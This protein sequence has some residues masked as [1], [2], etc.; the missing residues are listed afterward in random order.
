MGLS[1]VVLVSDQEPAMAAVGTNSA[2]TLRERDHAVVQTKVGSKS[3]GH[4][5]T[6]GTRI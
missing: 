3:K 6:L 1:R 4:S 2:S 5:G